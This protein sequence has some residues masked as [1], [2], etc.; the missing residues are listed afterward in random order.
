MGIN[1]P[2]QFIGMIPYAL[3]IIVV[4]GFVGRSRPPAAEGTSYEKE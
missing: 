2:H 4:S 3:T 1:V